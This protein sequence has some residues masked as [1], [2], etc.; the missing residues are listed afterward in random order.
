MLHTKINYR[1]KC[2]LIGIQYV[3]LHTAYLLI[4]V[5]ISFIKGIMHNPDGVQ[6]LHCH[7][8]PVVMN[9]TPFK[10]FSIFL[11]LVNGLT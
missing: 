11:G 10:V 7:S 4:N 2:L 1:Y 8:T 9:D 6:M 3:Y 5:F